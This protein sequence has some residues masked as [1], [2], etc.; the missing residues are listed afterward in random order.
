MRWEYT[1]N[2][3]LSNHWSKVS[4]LNLNTHQLRH[5]HNISK[6]H[7][8]ALGGQILTCGDCGHVQYKYHSC[9]N[10]HCPSCQG[11]RRE[12]WIARQQKYLLDVSYFH[13]VFTLPGELRPLCI[14]NPKLMYNLLFKASWET[15]ATLSKDK[16]YL[17]AQSGMTAILHSWSQ[18]LSLHPHLHCI[19]PGGG[20]S[21]SG[22]WKTTRSNGK[23]LF[24][25]EVL[26][27]IFKAIFLREFKALMKTGLLKWNKSLLDLLYAKK[28][29]VY[30]KRPFSNPHHVIEYLGRYTHKVGISNYRIRKVTSTHVTFEWKDY[31]QA[32]T[33]KEMT[34]TIEEFIRRFALHILPHRFVR[35]R[36][37]GLLSFHARKEK[38]STLQALQN[39]TP[40][41][42]QIVERPDNQITNCS[43]CMSENLI[44][45]IL[46][47]AN[48]RS[49]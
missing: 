48:S 28:W 44:E 25:K 5:L 12:E 6:C 33:K 3:I 17:G 9:R 13:V 32:G 36:H 8:A 45:T 41:S 30:A 1:V 29:V 24:P 43:N 21:K 7:T 18:N 26:R 31:R 49:P 16:K 47:K 39:Y 4:S 22:K 23:Y 46:P 10:R 27:I 20:V 14:H 11:S 34:L 15:I 42:I 40:P 19:I 2:D 37:Y 38:I 35:I